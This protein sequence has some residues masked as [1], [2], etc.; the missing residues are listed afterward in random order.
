[1][2]KNKDLSFQE[3][4][5]IE[6]LFNREHKK[7]YQIADL[8][9]R[10]RSNMYR[11]IKRGLVSV[12]DYEFNEKYE[13]SAQVAQKKHEESRS[14]CGTALK[15]GS[16][17]KY[18]EYIEN[19]I[20]SRHYSP[21]AA[22]MYIKKNP[23]PYDANL[24]KWTLYRYVKLK[25][26]PT[27]TY[28]DLPYKRDHKKKMAPVNRKSWKFMKA[29]SIENRSDEANK[30]M[31][32]G[33]FEGDTVVSGIG[34]NSCLLVLT[35]RKSRFEIMR[36]LPDRKS[37]TVLNEFKRIRKDFKM[38]TFKSITFDNGSEFADWKNIEKVCKCPVY[39][40]HPF[41]S[42]ERGSNENQN[43]IIRRFIPKGSHI[44]DYSPEYIKEVEAWINNLPRSCLN[45]SS[46]LEV[47][48]KTT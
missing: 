35:D 24:S 12:Y 2:R 29:D 20:K 26:F 17:I 13:Y 6:Y 8:L 22:L 48:N 47:F 30:R 41:S 32:I 5:T 34:D 37:M 7:P 16:N 21:Y 1:M 15:I 11:E 46:A 10:D 19:L 44:K 43:R 36:K 23:I 42:F 14:Q 28:K 40:A 18:L 39:F 33:H 27:L 4:C 38:I 45:G 3:R 9:S 25:I 31:E